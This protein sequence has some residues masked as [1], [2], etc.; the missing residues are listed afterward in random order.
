MSPSFNNMAMSFVAEEIKVDIYEDGTTY[1]NDG[2]C[3]VQ[4]DGNGMSKLVHAWQAVQQ[5]QG[6]A[7][8]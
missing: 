8:D 6:E 2:R 1:I 3:R 7:N 5:D 4:V